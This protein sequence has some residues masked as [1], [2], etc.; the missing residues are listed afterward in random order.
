MPP[1][2]GVLAAVVV[3]QHYTGLL[4]KR[5]WVRTWAGPAPLNLSTFSVPVSPTAVQKN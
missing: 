1:T 3:Q 5:L 4:F 2:S